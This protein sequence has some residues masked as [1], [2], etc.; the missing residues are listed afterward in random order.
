MKKVRAKFVCSQVTHFQ[1]GKEVQMNAVY[2]SVG[3]NKDFSTATPSG[4]FKMNISPGVM[5]ETFFE[6][7]KEYYLEFT[8]A[9][10]NQS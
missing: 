9:S 6:P 2:G 5:A 10:P 1:H 3:E 4:Q 7:G 8:E